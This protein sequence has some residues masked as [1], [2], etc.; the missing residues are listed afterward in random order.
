MMQKR[1]AYYDRR[2]F[3]GCRYWERGFL[4]CIMA[5]ADIPELITR[6]HFCMPFNRVI[7]EALRAIKCRPG[8][9]LYA[10]Y[11]LL[12]SLLKATG[13]FENAGGK[14]YL[15]EIRD[16]IGIPSAVHAFAAKLVELKA[17]L[18]V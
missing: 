9:D 15:E 16:M 12:V 14:A 5:G 17:G 1:G 18:P 13:N 6:D 7:F 11:N 2:Q 8:A 10:K 3:Q 4:S